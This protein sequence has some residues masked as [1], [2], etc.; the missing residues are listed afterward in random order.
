MH[1]GCA[2]RLKWIALCFFLGFIIVLDPTHTPAQFPGEGK[3]KKGKNRDFAGDGA[4]PGGGGAFPNQ[5]G[6][7]QGGFPSGGGGAFPGGGGGFPGGGGGFPRGGGGFPGGGGGAF[8]AGVGGFLGGGGGELAA[9][10]VGGRPGV[11]VVAAERGDARV[12]GA[13]ATRE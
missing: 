12:A 10:G 8:V 7:N 4:F 6:F 11:R 2:M 5:G 1:S 13:A 3:G 9:V